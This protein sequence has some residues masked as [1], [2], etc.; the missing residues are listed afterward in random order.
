[1]P[2]SDMIMIQIARSVFLSICAAVLAGKQYELQLDEQLFMY[3]EPETQ[4]AIRCWAVTHKHEQLDHLVV[5]SPGHPP[6][7]RLLQ[8]LSWRKAQGAGLPHQRPPVGLVSVDSPDLD[9]VAALVPLPV[10]DAQSHRQL[11]VQR[12]LARVVLGQPLFAQYV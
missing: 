8:T 5:A 7:N 4:L 9:P 1:M 6:G 3:V 10:H 12:S 2:S 11:I